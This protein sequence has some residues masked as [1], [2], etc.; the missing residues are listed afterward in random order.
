M[1]IWM[2][3]M[4]SGGYKVVFSYQVDGKRISK[5]SKVLVE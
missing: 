2:E 1:G 4:M 5:Q 3:E